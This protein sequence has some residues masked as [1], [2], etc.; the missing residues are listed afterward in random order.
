VIRALPA[1]QESAV[2]A[3][4][5]ISADQDLSLRENLE[6]VEKEILRLGFE[7]TGG[8]VSLLSRR[9]KIDRA[10]LHR[11]LKAYGIK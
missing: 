4:P 6:K 1:A 10:N 2:S 7:E 5:S 9:L 11:K 8:N 3:A